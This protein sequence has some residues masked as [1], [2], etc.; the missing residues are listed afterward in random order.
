MIIGYIGEA[1]WMLAKCYVSY[2]I[3]KEV[4]KER[5]SKQWISVL[6]WSVVFG[7]VLAYT[8]FSLHRI[9]GVVTNLSKRTVISEFMYFF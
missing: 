7:L 4:S 1:A 8:V 9:K 2:R 6:L 5:F 3:V